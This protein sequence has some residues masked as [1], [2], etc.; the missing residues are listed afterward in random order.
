M[1]AFDNIEDS[2]LHHEEQLEANMLKQRIEDIESQAASMT[3]APPDVIRA[4]K[5]MTAGKFCLIVLGT[6]LLAKLASALGAFAIMVGG[7][8]LLAVRFLFWVAI[9]G[10]VTWMVYQLVKHP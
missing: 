10:G 7:S 5:M 1:D 4:T 9:A 8:I 3:A 2:I 6:F